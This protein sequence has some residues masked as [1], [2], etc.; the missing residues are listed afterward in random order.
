MKNYIKSKTSGTGMRGNISTEMIIAIV[1]IVILFAVVGY[2]FVTKLA[3]L[4]R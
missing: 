3:I 2:V 4:G 1:L